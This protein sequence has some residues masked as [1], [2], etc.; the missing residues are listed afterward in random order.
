MSVID[1]GRGIPSGELTRIFEKFYR[2]G[3]TTGTG[4]GLGLTIAKGIVEAHGGRIWAAQTAGGGLT[5]QFSLPLTAL[6]P[7]VTEAELSEGVQP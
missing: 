5:I 2:N 4:L 7:Q 3:E 6:A 1:H